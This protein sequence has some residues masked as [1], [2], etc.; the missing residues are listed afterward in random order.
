ERI[1]IPFFTTKPEGSGIG[2]SLSRQ[3]IRL[4][5]GTIGVTSAPGAR[6]VF[7]LRF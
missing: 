5:K 6:T 3:I 7:K 4:H 2:L 1:F